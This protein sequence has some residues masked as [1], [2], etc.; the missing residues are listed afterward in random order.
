MDPPRSIEDDAA[1]MEVY[2]QELLA[3]NGRLA[4]GV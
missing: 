1:A 3:N 2:Y 4:G